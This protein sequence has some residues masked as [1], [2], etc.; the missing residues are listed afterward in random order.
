MSPNDRRFR[1]RALAFVNQP[2]YPRVSLTCQSPRR[3][4]SGFST[5]DR[6]LSDSSSRTSIIPCTIYSY[7]NSRERRGQ[8]EGGNLV[9]KRT[10]R[11]PILSQRRRT[12][13]INLRDSFSLRCGNSSRFVFSLSLIRTI[14]LQHPR[15]GHRLL[16]L[17]CKEK[18]QGPACMCAGGK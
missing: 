12:C 6:P 3:L 9:R 1:I 2:Q 15:T 14:F 4:G 13:R 17:I 16:W 18:M 8:N 7:P 5:C 10:P 11:P